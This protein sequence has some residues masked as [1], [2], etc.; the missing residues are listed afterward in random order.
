MFLLTYHRTLLGTRPDGLIGQIDRHGDLSSAVEAG[1]L[2]DGETIADGPLAG[3]RVTVTDG[4]VSLDRAGRFLCAE[5]DRLSVPV[6]RDA[7]GPWERFRPIDRA[8]LARLD[9]PRETDPETRRFAARVKAL[10]EAGEPVKVYFGAGEVPIPGFLNVDIDH[11][12]PEFALQHPEWYFN[13]PYI[14]NRVDVPDDCIDFIFDEDLIEH[15]PQIAQVQYLAETRRMLKPGCFHRV[16]TPSFLHAMR[17]HSD[18]A[19]GSDGVYTG[20]LRWGHIAIF[21]HA[22]LKEMAELVGYREI[23]FNGKGGSVSPHAI[24]DRRPGADR[25]DVFGNIYADLLK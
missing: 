15:V 16:N 23:A 18:F 20:E 24:D 13:F 17:L 7:A 5:I 1:Q 6:N 9:A 19:E 21:S 3:L 8:D 22:S 11:L 2:T 10:Q 4:M 25:D 12:A 14:G